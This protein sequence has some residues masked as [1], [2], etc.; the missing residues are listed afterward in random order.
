[1]WQLYDDDVDN[2]H[3]ACTAALPLWPLCDHNKDDPL[4]WLCALCFSYVPIG[5]EGC[6]YSHTAR[7]AI[8]VCV[9][10]YVHTRIHGKKASAP[11]ERSRD[12]TCGSSDVSILTI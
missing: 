1:M 11:F 6:A 10:V 2:P 12:S 8:Y 9:C 3:V 5:P 7:D 4:C